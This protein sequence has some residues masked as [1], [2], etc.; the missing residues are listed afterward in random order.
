MTRIHGWTAFSER[1]LDQRRLAKTL[2][3]IATEGPSA[4]Y[5][6]DVGAAIAKDVR[7][8]G[9]CLALSDF[10]FTSPWN[11]LIVSRNGAETRSAATSNGRRIPAAVPWTPSSAVERNETVIRTSERPIRPPMTIRRLRALERLEG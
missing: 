5:G 1:H 10:A 2:G 7:D 9:G 3:Q 11:Q 6:G 8:K 4:L